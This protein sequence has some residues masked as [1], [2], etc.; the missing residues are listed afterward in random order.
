[1]ANFQSLNEQ[2]EYTE[3]EKYGVQNVIDE[4]NEESPPDERKGDFPPLR[5]LMKGG[6]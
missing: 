6:G 3:D 5:F 4:I 1:M 2:D